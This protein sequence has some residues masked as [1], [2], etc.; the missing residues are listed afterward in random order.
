[1]PVCPTTLRALRSERESSFSTPGP[2]AVPTLDGSPTPPPSCLYRH[3]TRCLLHRS[4][5]PLAALSTQQCT[6]RR[7]ARPPRPPAPCCN[8]RNACAHADALLGRTV[9]HAPR[10]RCRTLH[11]AATR[12][13]A[14]PP[15]RWRRC[16]RAPR[17][18]AAYAPHTR[19]AAAAPA[20]GSSSLSSWAWRQTRPTAGSGRSSTPRT[21]AGPCGSSQVRLLRRGGG[22]MVRECGALG[23]VRL[24]PGAFAVGPLLLSPRSLQQQRD[25]NATP[26]APRACAQAASVA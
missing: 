14:T 26:R 3:A 23:L 19:C 1:M 10:R 9:R 18:P 8:D 22:A 16:P 13:P 21:P 15:P 4:A 2:A 25:A 24:K 17:A 5:S 11:C 20:P 7:R 12:W 6:A